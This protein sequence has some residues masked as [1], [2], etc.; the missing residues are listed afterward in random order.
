M[1]KKQ[2]V[3]KKY[4]VSPRTVGNWMSRK[5]I[6]YLRIGNVV[7]FD[8]LEVEKALSRHVIGISKEEGGLN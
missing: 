5:T 8:P 2:D 4:Q 3:A 6:P 1:L 7:R